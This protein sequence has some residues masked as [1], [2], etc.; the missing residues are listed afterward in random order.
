MKDDKKVIKETLIGKAGADPIEEIIKKHKIDTEIWYVE[1]FKI[2]DGKWNTA[3][4]KREQELTWTS[5]EQ[6]SETTNKDGDVSSTTT[7]HNQQI[8]RGHSKHYPEFMIAENKTYSIEIIFKR[9]PI[10]KDILDSFKDVVVNMPTIDEGI[11][12]KTFK[13]RIR[14]TGIAAEMA[15]VDAH[16]AKLAWER[17]TGY[18]NFDL[19]IATNDYKYVY[20]KGLDLI[21]PYKP[22]LIID[23]IGNDLYHMDNMS[24]KTTRGEHTLDVDGRIPKVHAKIFEIKRDNIIMARKLAPV[25]IIWVP[26]NHDFL[27]S[28]MLCYSLM[29]YFRND[30]KVI[31]DIGENPRKAMLW[32]NL[33]VGWNHA[34][35]GKYSVWVNELPQQFPKL[36]G[37]SKLREWHCGDQHKKVNTRIITPINTVG[38]VTIR[39]F[40]ALS[41]V[42]KWHTDNAFTDAVPG[43]DV[44]LWDKGEGVFANYTLWTGQYEEYRNEL[45][46]F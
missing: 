43:G 31:F 23:I 19:D 45:I 7:K 24:G 6:T 11:I 26:G 42:D 1:S 5:E 2:K 22:E 46:K 12:M 32:G 16:F 4:K 14:R 25:K 37:K 44:L 20:E 34:I 18:R 10:E 8:M 15:I 27:A 17:E 39:Q 38:G 40:T 9:M 3:A 41:P 28:Y 13:N 33:L 35:K 21:A 29:Q 30:P 36:W